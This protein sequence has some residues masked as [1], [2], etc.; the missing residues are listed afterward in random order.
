MG[1]FLWEPVKNKVT[2]QTTVLC[3][4]PSIVSDMKQLLKTVIASLKDRM[5]GQMNKFMSQYILINAIRDS[6]EM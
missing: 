2:T 3:P 4:L 6:E 5:G 1:T